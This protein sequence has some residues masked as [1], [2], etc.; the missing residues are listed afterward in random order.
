[1]NDCKIFI[2]KHTISKK[3]VQ[4]M[5]RNGSRYIVIQHQDALLD[6]LA[7]NNIV[8]TTKNRFK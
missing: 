8:I 2:I 3:R 1:M 4:N 6:R 5:L 7:K